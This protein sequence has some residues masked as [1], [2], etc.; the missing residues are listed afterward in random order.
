MFAGTGG[1]NAKQLRDLTKPDGSGYRHG[2]ID[3]AIELGITA[4]VI[5]RVEGGPGKPNMHYL[6]EFTEPDNTG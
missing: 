6:T 2:D 1:L 5:H 3:R 4:G